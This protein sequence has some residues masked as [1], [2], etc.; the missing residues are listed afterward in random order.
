MAFIISNDESTAVPC[1][2]SMVVMRM[3]WM[4]TL[5]K[6]EWKL[7]RHALL[8]WCCRPYSRSSCHSVVSVVVSLSL[9]RHASTTQIPFPCLKNECDVGGGGRNDRR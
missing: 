5:T 6:K 3:M 4:T 2:S 7:L 1:C 8:R 9:P